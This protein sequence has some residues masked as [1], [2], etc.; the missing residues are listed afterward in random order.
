MD[1]SKFCVMLVV[2]LAARLIN[3]PKT[4]FQTDGDS[5]RLG[6]LSLSKMFLCLADNIQS[7]LGSIM[8]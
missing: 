1:K 7:N 3:N 8:V 6:A 2:L 4:V 5:A